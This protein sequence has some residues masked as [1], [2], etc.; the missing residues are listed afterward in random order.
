MVEQGLRPVCALF[1][2]EDALQYGFFIGLTVGNS[3]APWH[4]CLALQWGNYLVHC[5]EMAV[6]DKLLW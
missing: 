2:S 5:Q 4:S 6:T 1:S 3:T